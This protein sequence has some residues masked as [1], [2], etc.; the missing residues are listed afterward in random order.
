M[1]M[2]RLTILSV[3]GMAVWAVPATVFCQDAK[4]RGWVGSL[5]SE[6]FKDRVEAQ[7]ELLEW[8]QSHPA[9]AE[10]FLLKEYNSSNDPEVQMRLREALLEIVVAEHQREKGQGYVGIQMREQPNVAIPGVNGV[11]SGVL[12][13]WVVEGSPASVAGLKVNDIIVSF[14]RL[15]WNGQ[16][17]VDAFMA[18]VKATKAGSVVQLEVLR[19]NELLKIPV[20]LVARPMGLPD[21]QQAGVLANGMIPNGF[22]IPAAP[23]LENM[24]K[25]RKDAEEAFFK[26]W[27]ETRKARRPP[28]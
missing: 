2:V 22:L 7:K 28:P 11:N 1:R 26:D 21:R 17:A 10:E 25:L 23:N 19:G 8:G 16:G 3:A 14:D 12:V 15:R 5:A 9:K 6:E 4:I 13:S 18:A 24:E 27:L 20:T